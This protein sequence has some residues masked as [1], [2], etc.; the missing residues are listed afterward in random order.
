MYLPSQLLVLCNRH[1]LEANQHRCVGALEFFSE[2]VEILLL[3]FSILHFVAPRYL[4]NAASSSSK[5]GLIVDAMLTFFMY[6]P[7]AVDGLAF[8]TASISARVLSTIL[9][10]SKETYRPRCES[11]RS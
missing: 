3:L 6:L 11:P 1:L 5:P 7:F 9:S 10:W 2:G 8:T 4:A